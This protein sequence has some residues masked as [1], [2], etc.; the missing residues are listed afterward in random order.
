MWERDQRAMEEAGLD[1][2]IFLT[3]GQG[4]FV[5]RLKDGKLGTDPVRIGQ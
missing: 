2:T 3:G 5:L 1:V 4:D